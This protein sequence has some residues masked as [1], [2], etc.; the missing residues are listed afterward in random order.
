MC[1]VVQRMP[2]FLVI[3]SHRNRLRTKFP[4]VTSLYFFSPALNG[5]TV[6]EL[7]VPALPSR[8]VL[9]LDVCS[10][11]LRLD[12]ATQGWIVG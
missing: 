3:I 5:V 11:D 1:A 7:F 6:V 4:V 12:T 9:F 8:G 10:S 2:S